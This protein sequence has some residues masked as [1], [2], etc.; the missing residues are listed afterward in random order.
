MPYFGNHNYTGFKNINLKEGVLRFE[1]VL[2]SA[3]DATYNSGDKAIYARGT[4]LYFW[5]GTVETVIGVSGGGGV[6]SWDELYIH[7]K[8]LTVND[9]TL[10]ISGT[11]SDIDVLTI[12]GDSSIASGALLQFDSNGAAVDIQGSDDTWAVSKLGEI[13]RAHV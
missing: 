5:N 10:N 4:A 6:S 7:D 2:S 11:T 3:M 12:K 13:G 9:T 8:T 1:N